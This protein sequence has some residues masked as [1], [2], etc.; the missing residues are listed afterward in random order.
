MRKLVIVHRQLLRLLE[1]FATVVVTDKIPT[2]FNSEQ[3]ESD[4]L[5][6]EPTD[7]DCSVRTADGSASKKKKNKMR[8]PKEGNCR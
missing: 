3:V 6:D 1:K 4:V 2:S 8:V 7:L 5:D